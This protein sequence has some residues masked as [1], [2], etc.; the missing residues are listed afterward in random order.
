[1]MSIFA[2]HW[3]LVALRGI[4]ALLFAVAVFSLADA[5]VSALA[6]CLAVYLPVDGLLAMYSGVRLRT[7][8]YTGWLLIVEGLIGVAL[9]ATVWWSK[10]SG[11]TLVHLFGAWCILT[12]GLELWLA[13]HVRREIESEWQLALAG[14]MSVGLGVVMLFRAYAGSSSLSGWAGF[15]GLF[16][17]MLL[18]GVSLRLRRWLA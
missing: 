14:L 7:E 16:F 11:A 12:G 6:V 5:P 2:K 18:L 9:G 15:Y 4:A 8:E 13:Y 1:M 3:W 10:A 17:G